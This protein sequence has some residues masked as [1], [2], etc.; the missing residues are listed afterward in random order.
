MPA[1]CSA[2]PSAGPAMPAPTINT[3]LEDL[4]A[5]VSTG[6]AA[7]S[8]F[9]MPSSMAR[10]FLDLAAVLRILRV[11]LVGP[12]KAG[13]YDYSLRRTL[14]LLATPDTT[15]T[16]YADVT[17]TGQAGHSDYAGP[18]AGIAACSGRFAV[19]CVSRPS[20]GVEREVAAAGEV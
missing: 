16:G 1:R 7:S 17:T 3:C 9:T 12:A 15:T 14:R 5:I 19:S 6:L 8:S 10:V 4:I 2:I 20:S 13:H 11:T 18:A